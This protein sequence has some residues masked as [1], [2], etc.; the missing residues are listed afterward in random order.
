MKF[1]DIYLTVWSVEDYIDAKGEKV[2][3]CKGYQEYRDYNYKSK[4]RYTA[5]NYYTMIL[6]R[7]DEEKFEEVKNALWQLTIDGKSRPLR[8]R[9]HYGVLRNAISKK[10]NTLLSVLYG[11]CWVIQKTYLQRRLERI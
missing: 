11:D 7:G 10:D 8:I 1:K 3:R 9:V 6:L 5:K 4:K 2:L